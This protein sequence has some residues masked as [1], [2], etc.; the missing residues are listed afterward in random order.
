MLHCY[1]GVTN[2]WRKQAR[3]K[4]G[5]ILAVETRGRRS[6]SISFTKFRF[7]FDA[8]GFIFLR[9]ALNRTKS[10]RV[11]TIPA[12]ENS[13]S[14]KVGPTLTFTLLLAFFPYPFFSFLFFLSL[15]FLL[16]ISLFTLPF[17]VNRALLKILRAASR[18]QVSTVSQRR[19]KTGVSLIPDA[20]PLATPMDLLVH[21]VL[22]NN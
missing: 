3:R 11:T 16:F 7:R 9:C 22:A 20:P 17:V 15:F 5:W 6:N 14:V 13:I 21:A 10:K 12:V 8:L 19:I 4:T 18:H 2:H 1:K